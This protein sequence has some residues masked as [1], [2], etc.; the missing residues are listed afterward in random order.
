MPE[1]DDRAERSPSPSPDVTCP[2]SFAERKTLITLK[3]LTIFAFEPRT[4]RHLTYR[5][6]QNCTAYTILMTLM[7]DVPMEHITI[8]D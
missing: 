8:R 7:E 3:Y 4:R 2:T 5:D 1:G 6:L